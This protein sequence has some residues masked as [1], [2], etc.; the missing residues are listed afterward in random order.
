MFQEPQVTSVGDVVGVPVI[1]QPGEEHVPPSAQ[2]ADAGIKL[3]Q[4]VQPVIFAE[5]VPPQFPAPF[6]PDVQAL[7]CVSLAAH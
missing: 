6:E 1:A 7:N 3:L 4:L 2:S 5:P